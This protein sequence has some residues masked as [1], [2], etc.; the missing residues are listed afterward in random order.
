M[1]FMLIILL[2][3]SFHSFFEIL[4]F[5]VILLNNFMTGKI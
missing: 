4:T 3:K 2:P 1:P 5:T